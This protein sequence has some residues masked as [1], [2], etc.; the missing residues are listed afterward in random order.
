MPRLARGEQEDHR[1]SGNGAKRKVDPETPPPGDVLGE[2]TAEERANDTG[3]DKDKAKRGH[4][5][6]SLLE[7]RD[8]ADDGE[9]GDEHARGADTLD[10]T[11][12]DQNV[13][14]LGDRADETAQLEPKDG[15]EQDP[16]SLD[17]GQEL[18]GEQDETALGEEV[19][20]DGEP[21]HELELKPR[22][23]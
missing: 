17:N 6:G 20:A 10:G 3:N 7:S 21:D 9:D 14:V 18:T 1:D 19:A 2:R 13:H 23:Q 8:D 12:K 5:A 11:T 16:F 15:A 22:T 4:E